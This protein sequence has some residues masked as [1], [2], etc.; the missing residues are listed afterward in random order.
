MAQL[1][2]TAVL[3][4]RLVL[5]S[6][7]LRHC[8][9]LKV[10]AMNVHAPADDSVSCAQ[11]W[12]RLTSHIAGV[13]CGCTRLRHF[14]V[15][16]S[17]SGLMSRLTRSATPGRESTLSSASALAWHSDHSEEVYTLR[18]TTLLCLS[19]S[20]AVSSSA[21]LMSSSAELEGVSEPCLERRG[22]L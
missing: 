17:A 21:E 2:S 8:W 18:R 22:E 6:L 19:A 1:L 3:E 13:S 20:S 11:A 9:F 12:K 10:H 15:L 14:P 4:Q 7:G 5:A 16:Q